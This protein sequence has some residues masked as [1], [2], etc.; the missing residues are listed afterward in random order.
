MDNL[1]WGA[2]RLIALGLTACTIVVTLVLTSLGLPVPAATALGLLLAGLMATALERR[3]HHPAPVFGL[4]LLAMSALFGIATMVQ[5]LPRVNGV[6][7]GLSTLAL[8]LAA[9]V[10]VVRLYRRRAGSTPRR[11]P[12]APAEA[13]HSTGVESTF[14]VR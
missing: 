6:L 1:S 2:T 7:V 11:R 12:T 9:L 8:E 3:L 13:A 10:G 4:A 14:S 5:A